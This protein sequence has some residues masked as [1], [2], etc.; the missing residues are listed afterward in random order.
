MSDSAM[1]SGFSTQQYDWVAQMMEK[2]GFYAFVFAHSIL[3][4]VSVVS[5]FGF[6]KRAATAP[7]KR[8]TGARTLDRRC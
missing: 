5:P 6:Q 8:Q 2:I 4:S 1:A 3:Y 7:N